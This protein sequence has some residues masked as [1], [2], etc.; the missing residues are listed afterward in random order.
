MFMV[1]E[2]WSWGAGYPKTS[3]ASVGMPEWNGADFRDP[4][5]DFWRGRGNLGAIAYAM[6]GSYDPENVVNFVTAHD[7]FTLRDLVSYD[8][9]HNEANGENNRDGESN[10]L[11]WNHGV[12]GETDDPAII[13]R[14]RK[15]MHNMLNTLFMSLGIPMLRAGDEKLYTQHGINNAY[16]ADVDRGPDNRTPDIHSLNWN[17]SPEQQGMFNVVSSL[18]AIRKRSNA[19]NP[20]TAP[21]MYSLWGQRIE[22]DDSYLSESGVLGVHIPGGEANNAESYITYINGSQNS[23]RISLPPLSGEYDVVSDS[24]TGEAN[25]AGIRVVSD[26]LAVGGMSSVILRLRRQ[27]SEQTLAQPTTAPEQAMA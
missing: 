16:C 19:G 2:P 20:H 25:P 27:S 24:E 23:V 18:I 6:R 21:A 3:F 1:A 8:E 4:V 7:G 5:R 13:E 11:S 15:T 9:K 10:N 26:S 12:E 17:L 22:H 14:R